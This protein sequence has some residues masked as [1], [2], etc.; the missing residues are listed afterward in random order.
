M[1]NEKIS[2]NHRIQDLYENWGEF[3]GTEKTSQERDASASGALKAAWIYSILG[4]ELPA[5]RV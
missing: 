5:G 4:R 1:E 2:L 3:P